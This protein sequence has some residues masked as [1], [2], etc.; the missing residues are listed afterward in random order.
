MAA[1]SLRMRSSLRR[2]SAASLSA[3][4][5]EG[6]SSRGRSSSACSRVS[7]AS[8]DRIYRSGKGQEEVSIV[9]RNTL[10]QPT[11]GFSMHK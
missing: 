5:R 4:T 7:S 2:N 3:S 1:S 6:A 9:K 10:R 8:R 11:S